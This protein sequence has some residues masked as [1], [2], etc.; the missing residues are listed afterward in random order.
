MCGRDTMTKNPGAWLQNNGRSFVLVTLWLD[1]RRGLRPTFF[2]RAC[3]V[4]TY[5]PRQGRKAATA[6]CFAIAAV[7]LAPSIYD[8]RLPIYDCCRSRHPR[9]NRK[10]KIVNQNVLSGHRQKIPPATFRRRGRAGAR[11]PDARQRHHAE[12]HRARVS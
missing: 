4:W 7:T 3:G 12:T 1:K 2:A 11:H 6:V 9:V 5:E 10:S 8:L